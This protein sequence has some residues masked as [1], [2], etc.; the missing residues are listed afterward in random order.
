[1]RQNKLATRARK[2]STEKRIRRRYHKQ[3][4][5]TF[6]TGYNSVISH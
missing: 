4:L 6:T 1:M 3:I 2:V 5:I